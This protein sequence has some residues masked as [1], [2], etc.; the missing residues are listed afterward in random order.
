MT[1]EQWSELTQLLKLPDAA[2]KP[3]AGQFEYRL[4]LLQLEKFAGSTPEPR[5]SEVKRQLE[6]AASFAAELLDAL[7]ALTSLGYEGLMDP[8]VSKGVVD[9]AWQREAEWGKSS[10]MLILPLLEHAVDA[11]RRSTCMLDHHAHLTALYDR[12]R[13]A[14]E[15]FAIKTKPGPDP[16]AAMTFLKRIS[17]IVETYTGKPLGKG[18]READFAR[19]ICKLAQH[20]VGPGTL[21]RILENL[22]ARDVAKNTSN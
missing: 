1:D 19:K 17:G 8:V 13:I 10:T 20:D 7:E 22:R 16:S 11:K 6:R 3:I 5:P 15:A 9:A 14:A 2:R 21:K 4:R 18:K 12:L